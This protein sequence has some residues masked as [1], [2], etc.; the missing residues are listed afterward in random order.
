M[1][2]AV[3][4][5]LAVLRPVPVAREGIHV[6]AAPAR[7]LALEVK[8]LGVVQEVVLPVPA[9]QAVPVLPFQEQVPRVIA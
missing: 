4:A 6:S 1:A 5:P 2:D 7:W 8:S 9:L 3:P